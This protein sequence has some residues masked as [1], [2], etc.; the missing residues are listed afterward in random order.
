MIGATLGVA[1]LGTVYV[2]AGGSPQNGL[3][4]SMLLRGGIQILAAA[5]AW[6]TTRST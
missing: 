4:L 2:S 1:I 3:R 5:L 6:H